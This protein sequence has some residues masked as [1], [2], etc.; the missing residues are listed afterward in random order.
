MIREMDR[1]WVLVRVS[2]WK[3]RRKGQAAHEG[4]W[5]HRG[6]VAPGQPERCDERV[7][8]LD[9]EDDGGLGGADGLGCTD[10]DADDDVCGEAHRGEEGTLGRGSVSLP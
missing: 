2:I 9:E 7:G 4:E 8:D 5:S 1:T 3:V 6:V 10:D